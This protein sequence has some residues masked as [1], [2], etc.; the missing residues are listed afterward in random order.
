[1][2]SRGLC[3]V[4]GGYKLCFTHR[5]HGFLFSVQTIWKNSLL[6]QM[7]AITCNTLVWWTR[8]LLLCERLL[9]MAVGFLVNLQL[10]V[11]CV[12]GGT[13]WTHLR[14]HE[15]WPGS[16]PV[17]KQREEWNISG[18]CTVYVE[19]QSFFFP[20]YMKTHSLNCIST[21]KGVV[22]SHLQKRNAQIMNSNTPS[23]LT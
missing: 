6:N 14:R 13:H 3:E 18:F 17:G 20:H 9:L 2:R 10:Y 12:W 8:T 15:Q 11:Y 23:C 7:Q 19:R 4:T 22:F 21:G 16:A 5:L 1:M